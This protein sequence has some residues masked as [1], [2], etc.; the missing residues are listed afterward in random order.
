[1]WSASSVG[2]LLANGNEPSSPAVSLFCFNVLT[3]VIGECNLYLVSIKRASSKGY[4][5]LK[6]VIQLIWECFEAWPC[7]TRCCVHLKL[8]CGA[9]NTAWV[10]ATFKHRLTSRQRLAL[11]MATYWDTDTYWNVCL[12]VEAGP[13]HCL[14]LRYP[15]T[16]WN[17]CLAVE[18]GPPHCILLRYPDILIE[19]FA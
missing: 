8:T 16:Y 13:P 1:M 4:H 2:S 11:P 18:A 9:W 10:H 7:Q 3:W 14:L 5:Y 17:V 19:I 15:N 12:A 6:N